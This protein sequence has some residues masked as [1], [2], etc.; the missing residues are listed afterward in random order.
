M[1][2]QYL[3]NTNESATVSIFQNFSELNK[4]LKEAARPVS[5]KHSSKPARVEKKQTAT[6]RR[7]RQRETGATFPT[8]AKRPSYLP[9]VSGSPLSSPLPVSRAR[10]PAG[11]SS[12]G[13]GVGASRRHRDVSRHAGSRSA[14]VSSGGGR[15]HVVGRGAPPPPTPRRRGRG[16]AGLGLRAAARRRRHPAARVHLL[17]DGGRPGAPGPPRRRRRGG[18]VSLCR[19]SLLQKIWLASR[20]LRCQVAV[21]S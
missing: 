9:V 12:L 16:G 10:G 1:I 17:S 5:G 2:G 21:R 14:R 19:S 20:C 3:S 7:G 8:A 11:S 6:P 15:G 4:A 18:W 13:V